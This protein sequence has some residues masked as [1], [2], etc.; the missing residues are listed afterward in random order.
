MSLLW[1]ET[2]APIPDNYILSLRRLKGLLCHLKENLTVLQEYD[3]VIRDQ[4]DKKIVKAESNHKVHYLPH[5]AVI[6]YDNKIGSRESR[7]ITSKVGD[8][9]RSRSMISRVGSL[10]A[11]ESACDFCT[12]ATSWR[13]DHS[14]YGS[15]L[16]TPSPCKSASTS[17]RDAK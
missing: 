2:H 4:I 14:T 12:N 11:K 3:F 6:R 16:P 9:L 5:H 1:K 7:F 13:V 10:S 8:I 15:S 17:K